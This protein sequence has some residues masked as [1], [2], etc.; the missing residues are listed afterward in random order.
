MIFAGKNILV[1]GGSSGIGLSVITALSCEGAS[2]YNLSR[3][4]NDHWP[5]GINHRE[6]DVTGENNVPA[7]FLPDTLHGLLY[8]VGSINIKPFNRLTGDDFIND[9]RINVT[10]AVRAIQTAL[11]ALKKSGG[12]S[13]V[14]MSSVA[15][16]VGMGFHSSVAAAKGAVNGLTLALAAELAPGKIR[17]NAVAPS[18]TD[19]R[20]AAQ[21]LNTPEKR[22]ASA[23]RHPL[24]NVGTPGD[25][26]RA[27]IFL[28]SPEN[29]WVTGQ[30]IGVDGGMSNVRKS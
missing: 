16:S 8:A 12:A 27:I 4:A 11:P 18:L 21:L 5:S 15:A 6:W 10:G 26:A 23:L 7:D 17:V 22:E 30:I 3:T 28:L 19:T 20:L 1:I 25:I 2:V 9:F 14:L 24:G 29:S 13:V